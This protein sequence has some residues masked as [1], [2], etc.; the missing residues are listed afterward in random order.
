MLST[1]QDNK[2]LTWWSGWLQNLSTEILGAFLTIYF[3][4]KIASRLEEKIQTQQSKRKLQTYLYRDYLNKLTSFHQR[5][6]IQDIKGI[7][8]K[9]PSNLII[10]TGDVEEI[11]SN[12]PPMGNLSVIDDKSVAQI[13]D[14]AI[15]AMIKS[16]AKSIKSGKDNER[17][18]DLGFEYELLSNTYMEALQALEKYETDI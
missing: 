15:E 10:R 7:K 4:E 13:V 11:I 2:N 1:A 9:L 6:V 5:V 3:I 18:K 8:G 14:T 16:L 17:D 12:T